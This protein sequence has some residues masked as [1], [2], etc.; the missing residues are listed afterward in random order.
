[1]NGEG[2]EDE[3][4]GM[5]TTIGNGERC[6]PGDQ[7]NCG[8]GGKAEN[9]RLTYPKGIAIGPDGKVY[10]ADGNNIR[11]VDENGIMH[12]VVGH[13]NHRS[14][15]KPIPCDKAVSVDEVQLN[16]PTGLAI[17]PLDGTLHFIDDN[18]VMQLTNDGRI[19][20]VAGRP[21]HCPPPPNSNFQQDDPQSSGLLEPQ[22]I[23]FSA[24][25]ELYIAESD[26]KRVNRVRRVVHNTIEIIAGGDTSCNCM[27]K[28]CSCFDPD[29]YLASSTSFS[30]ISSLA[31]SPDGKIYVADEG[32]LR[33]R[34]I[35]SQMP[36]KEDDEVFEVPDPGAQ[37][38]YI[39]NRYSQHILT[40][41]LLT[42]CLIYSM[43]YS[44]ATSTGQ[45]HSFNPIRI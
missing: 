42:K 43:E 15:W 18:M 38:L 31:V 6:L 40:K 13:Q 3:S 2:F 7:D 35:A 27:E 21:L 5:G 1:M 32:N 25:G 39:F 14:N 11:M 22:D 4:N 44:Q 45:F 37:E 33:I 17:N 8:D 34:A 20:I 24:N 29:S 36:T 9:A 26:S 30:A 23:S 41:D 12:T 28:D 19:K 16:W 10:F